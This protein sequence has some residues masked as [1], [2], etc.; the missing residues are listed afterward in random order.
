[1][2]D[3]KEGEAVYKLELDIDG[4]LFE[5]YPFVDKDFGKTCSF[6]NLLC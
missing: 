4:I 2:N 5:K 1:M 3:D 6:F